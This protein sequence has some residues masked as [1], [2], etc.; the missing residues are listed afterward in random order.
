MSATQ[1]TAASAIAPALIFPPATPNDRTPMTVSAATVRTP[2]PSTRR[3][4]ITVNAS[5]TSHS[6]VS[7]WDGESKLKIAP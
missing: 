1:A 2:S 5:A 4:W 6:V 7:D 3:S